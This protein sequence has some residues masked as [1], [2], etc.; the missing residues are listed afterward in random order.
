MIT[1]SGHTCALLFPEQVTPQKVLKE[2]KRAAIFG[3]RPSLKRCL[4]QNGSGHLVGDTM[5]AHWR[6]GR[7]DSELDDVCHAPQF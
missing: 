6:T 2:T 3:G 4:F 7:F 1:I 5:D